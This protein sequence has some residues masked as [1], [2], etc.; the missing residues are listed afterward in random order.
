M[1]I[2]KVERL[3]K[4]AAKEAEYAETKR[5]FQAVK[6]RKSYEI[7]A[8]MQREEKIRRER[9]RRQLP[10]KDRFGG[11]K[12]RIGQVHENVE[13][14]SQMKKR[15]DDAMNDGQR[16]SIKAGMESDEKR[17]GIVVTEDRPTWT[18]SPIRGG[19]N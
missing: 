13:M 15:L 18:W 6:Y 9:E 2:F 10:R 17:K 1:C 4:R 7:E 8:R 11:N 3:Q 12:T 5:Q 19:I 14:R 16:R